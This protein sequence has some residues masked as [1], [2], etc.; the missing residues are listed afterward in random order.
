M[1]DAIDFNDGRE[2]PP[3][4][5]EH[6][7]W[8]TMMKH[9]SL[10]LVLLGILVS[11]GDL[12]AE[13]W[14]QYRGPTGL[15]YTVA[16]SLPLKWSGQVSEAIGSPIIVG[17][18]VYRLHTPG[19]LKCWKLADG[20]EAY[21]NRLDGLSSTWS[22]P[23]ADAAGRIY[24]ASGGKSHVLKAGPEGEILAEDDLGDANHATPAVYG[25]RLIIVG[26]KQL[27]C[28]GER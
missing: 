8:A 5:S 18:D 16:K 6:C 28:V 22:S 7:H 19:I 11:R 20:K 25:E 12:R 24:F 10:A 21:A 1:S 15:G 3:S 13:E 14:P 23:L 4:R 17:D 2:R 27:Y 9:T 26:Q